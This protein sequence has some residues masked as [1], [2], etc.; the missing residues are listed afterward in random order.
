MDLETR[1]KRIQTLME[2]KGAKTLIA[3]SKARQSLDEQDPVT[4]LTGFR[5]LG[6]SAFILGADGA[7]VLIT[8]PLFDEERARAKIQATRIV[9]TDD[10]LK[11]LATEI[12]KFSQEG[13]TGVGLDVLPNRMATGVIDAIGREPDKIDE[14]FYAATAPKTDAEVEYARKASWIAERAYERLLAVARPGMRECDLAVDLNLHMRSLGANDIFLLMNGLP[15]AKG[16]ASS[17]ARPL[18]R[19]DIILAEITPSY[20]GQFAQICRT[21]IVGEPSNVARDK[22]ALVVQAMEAGIDAVRPG[23]HVSDICA[24]I[25]SV[26]R[27][28]GYG[29]YCGPPYN[30]RR[31]HGLGCGSA[32]PGSI[33]MENNTL[34]EENMVFVVHPNQFIPETGYL[35][36]GEPVRVSAKGVEVL[37]ERRA[38]LGTIP[39]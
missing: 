19:G 39:A 38:S 29:D 34:V 33:T 37:T 16:V 14:A 35:L 8:T 21:A 20:E 26:L 31:G 23:I 30:R 6:P 11:P 1:Q 24:A 36:C 5:S 15:R 32:A 3:L 4:H 18:E 28:N 10:L 17:S 2:A 7:S 25:D 27:A 12:G 13:M 22:Y 9:A